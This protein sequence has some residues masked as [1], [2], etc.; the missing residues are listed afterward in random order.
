M[1]IV[2]THFITHAEQLQQDR[3]AAT[4][5]R[6]AWRYGPDRAGEILAGRDHEANA[7]LGRWLTLGFR[8]E[9]L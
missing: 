3:E 4:A 7:D 8:P 1:K 6:L 2:R 9:K 5:R